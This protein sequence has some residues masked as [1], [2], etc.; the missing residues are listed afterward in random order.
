M[1]VKIVYFY[2]IA[3]HSV[4]MYKNINPDASYYYHKKSL[5][6]CISIYKQERMV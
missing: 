5:Y 4:P 1:N 2:K 3:F 6:K